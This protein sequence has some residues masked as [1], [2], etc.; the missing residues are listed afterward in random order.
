[1]ININGVSIFESCA[2]WVVLG[3]AA[4]AIVLYVMQS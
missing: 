3:F 4:I 1:M 2:F